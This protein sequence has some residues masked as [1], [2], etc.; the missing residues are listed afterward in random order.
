MLIGFLTRIRIPLEIKIRIL[1]QLLKHKLFYR[2]RN[3]AKHFSIV[4]N[5]FDV[6]F[7]LWSFKSMK[8]T[9]FG[10]VLCKIVL[11]YKYANCHYILL[12]L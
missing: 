6:N 2:I 11:E 9:T 8:G 3:Q 4:A 7:K 1:I 10:K 5:S 12:V